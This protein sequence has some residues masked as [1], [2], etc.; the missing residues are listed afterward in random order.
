MEEM[1]ARQFTV[2][3]E[4]IDEAHAIRLKVRCWENP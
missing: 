2:V 3:E 4:E 1:Q